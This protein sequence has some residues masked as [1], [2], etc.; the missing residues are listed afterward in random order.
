MKSIYNEVLHMLQFE[1][2]KI[3]QRALHILDTESIADIIKKDNTF[4]FESYVNGNNCP[5]YIYDYLKKFIKRKFEFNY[6]YDNSKKFSPV[7]K[8]Q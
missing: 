1:D 5:Q 6:L 4:W 3:G 8:L 7:K 2:T